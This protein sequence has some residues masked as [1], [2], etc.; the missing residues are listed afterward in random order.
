MTAFLV[1]SWIH[2]TR[3]LSTILLHDGR[4]ITIVGEG[5]DELYGTYLYRSLT[6]VKRP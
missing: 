4:Q 6:E 5:I 1:P 3:T 2:D